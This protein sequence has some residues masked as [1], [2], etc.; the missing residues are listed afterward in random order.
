VKGQ[1]SAV[2]SSYFRHETPWCH[3]LSKIAH[4]GWR[5]I[6]IPIGMI[7]TQQL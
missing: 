7:A 1:N 3:H 5:K 4:S 2:L 6:H